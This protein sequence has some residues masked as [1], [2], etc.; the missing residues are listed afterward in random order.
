MAIQKGNIEEIKWSYS[1]GCTTNHRTFHCVVERGDLEVIKWL[2][3][4][5]C[6]YGESMLVT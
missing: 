3:S 6:R 1:N 4:N 5:N 2:Y